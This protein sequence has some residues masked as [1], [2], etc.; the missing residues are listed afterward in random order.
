MEKTLIRRMVL[1]LACCLAGCTHFAALHQDL[2]ESRTQLGRLAGNIVSDTC[3]DC[4]TI[5]VA[6]ETAESKTTQSHRVYEKPGPFSMVTLGSTRYLFAF[7]DL[8]NDFQFQNNEPHTWLRLPDSFGAGSQIEHLRLTLTPE[9][10]GPLPAFGSLFD[11]RGVTPGVIDVQFGELAD[12]SDTR[13]D[14][15]MAG[16]G[17]WQPLRFM[18]EGYAGIYFL[19]KYDANKT[20]VLF[21]HGISGSPRNF[22][23]LIAS[24]DRRKFQPWVFYYPTGIRLAAM[25]DGLFG[26]LSELHHRYRFND[27]H[28]IAHS[29]GGLVS[30]SYLKACASRSDCGYLRSFTSISSPFGGDGAAQ[31]GID[32]APVAIP[33]WESMVPTTPF[34]RDLFAEP[35]P[36]G[37]AH[38]LLFGY[39]NNTLIINTS[40]DGT[41]SLANQ[42]RREAQN[43]A[44]SIRGFNEDHISILSADEVL[45]Y[46]NR[47]LEAK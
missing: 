3:P 14:D 25:S 26:I 47:L 12:L 38:H 20:P 41:I 22:A 40:S 15:D 21:V 1:L 31:I 17:L 29:M 18:K 5:V 19:E 44:T 2:Q 28:L 9:H 24:L 45:D 13:F 11:L 37:V 42:L 27:M 39:R 4:P 34:L 35:L 8:N 30:R 32:Y 6:L 23:S 46:I 16:L 36:S 33:V 10:N 43:Q 7:N